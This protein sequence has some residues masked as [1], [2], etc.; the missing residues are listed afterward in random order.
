MPASSCGRWGTAAHADRARAAREYPHDALEER[1][2]AGA[3]RAYD[4]DV[5]AFGDLE[6]H[7]AKD[8]RPPEAQAE[9]AD[10][11]EGRARKF[12]HGR[13]QSASGWRMRARCS[14]SR[15]NLGPGLTA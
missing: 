5:F 10:L 9:A 7:V 11:D 13:P 4:R 1:G 8:P 12:G 2:L 6:R 3:V 15:M 14:T